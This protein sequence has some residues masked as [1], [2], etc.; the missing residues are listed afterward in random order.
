MAKKY[1]PG[2]Y[3]DWGKTSKGFSYALREAGYVMSDMTKLQMST[4]AEEFLSE[5]DAKWPQGRF[6]DHDHPWY[7]GQLHDSIAIRIAQSNRTIAERFMPPAA[8][9]PEGEP[10]IFLEE[11]GGQTMDGIAGSILGPDWARRALDNAALYSHFLSPGIQVQLVIGVPYADKLN[12]GSEGK[13]GQP[14]GKHRGFFD[15]ITDDLIVKYDDYDWNGHFNRNSIEVDVDGNVVKV[16]TR[17]R[18][19]RKK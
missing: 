6:G 16:R 1:R 3:H 11:D 9:M 8:I 14:I 17:S 5:L 4:L 13:Y 12:E 18:G 10:G 19:I 15:S 7:S 2:R